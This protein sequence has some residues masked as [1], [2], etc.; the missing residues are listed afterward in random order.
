MRMESV[1][2]LVPTPKSK[3]LEVECKKCQETYVVFSKAASPLVCKCGEEI[4]SPSG[5]QARI[6]GKIKKVLD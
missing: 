3:F 1:K 5:G 4:L 2:K 6:K